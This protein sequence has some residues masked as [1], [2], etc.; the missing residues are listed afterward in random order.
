[1]FQSRA[2]GGFVRN[3]RGQRVFDFP[4]GCHL[5]LGT[6]ARRAHK[7]REHVG[8]S[9]QQSQNL[10]V[11]RQLVRPDGRQHRL[12]PVGEMHHGIETEACATTLDGVCRTKNGI[13][14]FGIGFA[15]FEGQKAGLKLAEHFLTFFKETPLDPCKTL[16]R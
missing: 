2:R 15:A 14:D 1:M 9:Q 3:K 13:D 8:R 10:S 5:C 12:H 6:V 7:I 16:R 11:Q 4:S